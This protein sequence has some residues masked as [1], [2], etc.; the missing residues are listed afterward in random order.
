MVGCT[1]LASQT[2]WLPHLYHS[3]HNGI[4][5]ELRDRVVSQTLP[6]V[7]QTTSQTEYVACRTIVPV[8]SIFPVSSISCPLSIQGRMFDNK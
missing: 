2:S 4:P 1:L 3:L 5:L 8:Y 7:A 6:L